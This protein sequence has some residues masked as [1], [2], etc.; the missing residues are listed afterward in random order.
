[1]IIHCTGNTGC[2]TITDFM[3]FAIRTSTCNLVVFQ[4]RVKQTGSRVPQTLKLE[5]EPSDHGKF[6]FDIMKPNQHLMYD[7]VFDANDQYKSKERTEYFYAPQISM[8]YI[9]CS[10]DQQVLTFN[11]TRSCARPA[12]VQAIQVTSPVFFVQYPLYQETEV[13]AFPL[14]LTVG[15]GSDLKISPDL[16]LWLANVDKCYGQPLVGKRYLIGTDTEI[17]TINFIVF[18]KHTQPALHPFNTSRVFKY[19]KQYD[20]T[21]D[22]KL[23]MPNGTLINVHADLKERL[24]VFPYLLGCSLLL[25]KKPAMFNNMPVV[26]S[27]PAS[28]VTEFS[29]ELD[30]DGKTVLL[31][32]EQY[33][34]KL[35]SDPSNRFWML[36]KS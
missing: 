33:T 20:P 11:D 8:D 22:A 16:W 34:Y 35:G 17:E 7:L 18:N 19:F 15:S 1:M 24:V 13:L 23:E 3:V 27:S 30:S 10:E 5:L 2:T 21:R 4:F 9:S 14:K 28:S 32:S 12:N 26:L 36:V 29:F 6:M 25:D 31:K